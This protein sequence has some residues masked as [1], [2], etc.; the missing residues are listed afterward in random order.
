[1]TNPRLDHPAVVF[2]RMVPAI[3]VT[4]VAHATRAPAA[5]AASPETGGVSAVGRRADH[6]AAGAVTQ[7]LAE[8]IPIALPPSEVGRV[9]PPG[10]MRTP[11]TGATGAEVDARAAGAA[12]RGAAPAAG[13][14]ATTGPAPCAARAPLSDLPHAADARPGATMSG[15]RPLV[16][17]DRRGPAAAVVGRRARAAF[18]ATARTILACAVAVVVPPIHELRAAIGWDMG[19]AGTRERAPGGATVRGARST[20][21]SARLV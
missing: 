11:K 13:R 5:L 3:P 7:A 2:R 19:R 14:T 12:S 9:R 6:R 21:T 10:A 18:G 4:R 8:A 1:M 20:K 15:P 17:V 16:V